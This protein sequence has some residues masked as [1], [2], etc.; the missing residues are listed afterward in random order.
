[1]DNTTLSSLYCS[2][3]YSLA[4]ATMGGGAGGEAGRAA[5]EA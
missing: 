5:I 3:W 1:M 4:A 2:S